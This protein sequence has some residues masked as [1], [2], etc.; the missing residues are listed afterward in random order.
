MAS[1]KQ[2]HK[3]SR[4]PGFIP[5]RRKSLSQ[6]LESLENNGIQVKVV[7][8]PE[9]FW[10]K[11]KTRLSVA[12]RNLSK[13]KELGISISD[14][15]P[16]DKISIHEN[17]VSLRPSLS[18]ETLIMCKA[19]GYMP[20]KTKLNEKLKKLKKQLD[21]AEAKANSLSRKYE[22]SKK[23]NSRY[24]ILDVSLKFSRKVFEIKKMKLI[25][26]K[27]LTYHD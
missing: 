9:S 12:V 14:L 25:N 26:A 10:Y 3:K 20:K 6:L 11:K 2:S 1:K 7:K 13:A 17:K 21:K 24:L 22:D 15:K 27:I 18:Q 4:I 23:D 19:F 8:L 16:E 5:E